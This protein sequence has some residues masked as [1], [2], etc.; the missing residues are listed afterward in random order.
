[1]K[2][3]LMM[4]SLLIPLIVSAGESTNTGRVLAVGKIISTGGEGVC[5]LKIEGSTFVESCVTATYQEVYFG[6]IG[7][8]KDMWL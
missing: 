6:C 1:M 4:L 7:E 8:G 2:N 3:L 5:R